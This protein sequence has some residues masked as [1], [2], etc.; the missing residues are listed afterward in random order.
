VADIEWHG[1]HLGAPGWNDHAC[2]VLSFTMA[3]F[4]EDPDLHV[5]LNM[6][7][8]DLDFDLP[9]IAGRHWHR[10]VDTNLDSPE[11]ILP[12]DQEQ[13]VKTP[14]YRAAGRSVVILIAK[15]T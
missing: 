1:L 6:D 9:K 10:V 12:V 3:G 2:R 8:H 14:S 13:H 5:I 15:E 4:D 11:D 7:D